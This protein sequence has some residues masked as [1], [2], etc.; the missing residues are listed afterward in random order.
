MAIRINDDDVSYFGA[1]VS[2]VAFVGAIEL[3][4]ASCQ[5]VAIVV[6]EVPC[7]GEV[8][9]CSAPYEVPHVVKD[10]DS[11]IGHCWESGAN[12][13]SGFGH[14]RLFLNGEIEMRVIANEEGYVVGCLV[15]CGV[16]DSVFQSVSSFLQV[17]RELY[18]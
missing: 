1:T 3:I 4:D 13:E 17:H 16:I 9:C 6:V 14:G 15:A 2:V 12:I 18:G 7:V 8:A 11:D 5:T 10:L